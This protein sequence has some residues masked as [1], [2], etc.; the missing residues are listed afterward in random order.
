MDNKKSIKTIKLHA[1]FEKILKK[2]NHKRLL[3]VDH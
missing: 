1:F 3:G 2:M